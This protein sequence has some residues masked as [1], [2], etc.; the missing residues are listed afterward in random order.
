LGIIL[1]PRYHHTQHESG[2][3]DQVNIS[4]FQQ[5]LK[6]SRTI[7]PP[8]LSANQNDYN[9]SGLAN[10]VQIRQSCDPTSRT[11]TGLAGG[12]EG[13]I[14]IIT[15]I[16]TVSDIVLSNE[17]V[18]SIAANRFTMDRT[19]LT[20][21]P[22]FCAIFRYDLLSSRWRLVATNAEKGMIGDNVGTGEGQVYKTKQGDTLLFR[23][24]KQ[25]TNVTITQNTD[26]ITISSAAGSGE[27]NTSSNVGTGEGLIA[28]AKSGVNLP[29]KT[30][31][32]GTNVTITNGTDEVTINST[33][34]GGS[35][36]PAFGGRSFGRWF[37][38]NNDANASNILSGH[39]TNIEAA[40][41][42]LLP[43]SGFNYSGRKWTYASTSVAAGLRGSLAPFS[44]RQNPYL[45]VWY[46]I[47][48]A[49][50]TDLRYFM[51]FHSDPVGENLE[52]SSIAGDVSLFGMFK[53][54]NNNYS[55]CLHN[56][57]DATGEGSGQI[58]EATFPL[59]VLHRVRIL[60]VAA[61]P[62]WQIS[63]DGGAY[64]DFTTEIPAIDTPLGIICMSSRASTTST[65]LKMVTIYTEID[66][67]A[68]PF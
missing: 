54:S 32:Q 9:P 65:T 14:I 37:G 26:D 49:N 42:I 4:E 24:L 3:L 39:F 60:G 7:T 61:T 22:S 6:L 18:S 53:N 17:S 36:A 64:T 45:E 51:G 16:G 1:T 11:I 40:G 30:L 8:T 23:E 5:S 20:L 62:K 29:F 19:T 48:S 34:S 67:G 38:T 43:T 12:S 66:S 35:L 63:Y 27:A 33:A 50:V 28:K 13:R 2:G 31:K 56:D 59:N 52:S 10:C 15:N 58:G 57:G 47:E 41:D 68:Q 44:L 55:E 21:S 46:A 25:G